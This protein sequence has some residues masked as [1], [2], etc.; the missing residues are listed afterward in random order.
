MKKINA[1]LILIAVLSLFTLGVLV[2][3]A[4]NPITP[5]PKPET[6]PTP[7]VDLNENINVS[8]EIVVRVKED[9]SKAGLTGIYDTTFQAG[10][11]MRIDRLIANNTYTEDTPLVIYNPFLTN[12]QSLYV[13]FETKEPY[14]VSYVVHQPEKAYEDFEV[15]VVPSDPST[16]TVHEFQIIGLIP[17]STNLITIRLTDEEGEV[18]LRRFYYENENSVEATTLQLDVTRG[19]KEVENEDKTVSIVAASNETASQGLFVTFPVKNEL[20][21]YVRYYDNLGVQRGELPL[22]AF[23]SKELI[24]VDDMMYYKVSD[25]KIAGVNRLGQVTAVYQV[26]GYSFGEDFCLDKNND[27]LVLASDVT[28]SSVHDRILLIE[29]ATGAITELV[30]MGN[31]L[32]AYKE[33]CTMKNG[34][35]DWIHLSAID[36]VDGNRVVVYAEK[37]GT[38]IKIRRLYNDPRLAYMMGDVELFAGTTYAEEFFLR[39][40]NE[41]EMHDNTPVLL[42]QEYDLIR[43]SRHYLDILNNNEEKSYAKGEKPYSVYYRYLVDEAEFGVRLVNSFELPAT[44]DEGSI[45]W[46]G[47][48]VIMNGDIIPEFFEYDS[49]FQIINTYRYEEPIVTKTEDE[50]EEEE[51]NPSPDGTVL[52]ARVMKEDFLSYYFSEKPVLILPEQSETEENSANNE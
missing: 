22:E 35:L 9:F 37:T 30:D 21:P 4:D 6:T 27:I 8:R 5:M 20:A 52:F 14:A 49:D 45:Q 1:I 25:S 19:T 31:L 29:R 10:I 43:E 51:D 47:N 36:L 11:R 12:S 46:Y 28:T 2:V 42:Y 15:N 34:V 23:G 38:V 16:S 24:V 17:D 41:F 44:G 40:D 48:H 50:L 33:K 26:F 3:L 7:F 13:Y 39:L 18:Y 32:P